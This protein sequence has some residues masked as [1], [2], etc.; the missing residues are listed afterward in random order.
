MPQTLALDN[1]H[2]EHGGAF[3]VAWDRSLPA[4]YSSA[5]GSATSSSS[6]D[7]YAAVRE[8]V[9][10]LDQSYRGVIDI[11]FDHGDGAPE[12]DDIVGPFLQRLVSTHAL[13]LDTEC[14]QDSCL[15]SAKGRLLGAF[16]LHRLDVEHFRLVLSEPSREAL[17]DAFD[18][19]AFLDDIDVV[20]RSDD[21]AILTVAG[22]LAADVLA[23]LT[24]G[25][26]PREYL[27][28]TSTA[29]SGLS[30]DI[31]H[32]TETGT[33]GYELWVSRSDAEALWS[34]LAEATRAKGGFCV[35]WEAAE[36]LRIEAGVTRY[37]FDYDEERLPPEVNHGHRLTFDKCYVGQEVVA[38]MRTYGQASRRL[39][40]VR[41]MDGA[42]V[43]LV[44]NAKILCGE[45]DAG[46]ITTV[47]PSWSAGGPTAIALIKR[48]YWEDVELETEAGEPIEISELPQQG[49][50]KR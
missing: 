30:V 20:D 34:T 16:Q 4:Y 15:L 17:I 22:P 21:V 11:S 27:E 45:K 2:R 41:G 38:R 48:K 23:T 18:K 14:G 9:G 32:A 50:L 42:S 13:S 1:Y 35:G 24:D 28:R 46:H 49:C 19:Y 40:F 25:E 33:S 44:P 26:L 12:G 36:A 43:S 37:L 39:F 10:V 7:E 29:V 31:V 3:V 6:T 47:G 8:R 5:G